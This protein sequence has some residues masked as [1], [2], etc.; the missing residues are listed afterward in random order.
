MFKGIENEELS[1]FDS[2]AVEF[3]LSTDFQQYE[4]WSEMAQMEER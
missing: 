2:A 4:I 1:L 3:P